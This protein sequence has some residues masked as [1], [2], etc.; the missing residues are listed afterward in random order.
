MLQK[1]FGFFWQECMQSARLGGSTHKT[2]FQKGQIIYIDIFVCIYICVYI[3]ILLCHPSKF[4]N[5][6]GFLVSI[7][8]L[9]LCQ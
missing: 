2:P 5:L 4:S 7:E 9:Q 1:L 6:W 8:E 3:M